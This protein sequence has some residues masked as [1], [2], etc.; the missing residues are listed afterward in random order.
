MLMTCEA[1][2]RVH[3]PE[4][5]IALEYISMAYIIAVLMIT[6]NRPKVTKISGLNT[7]FISGLSVKLTIVITKIMESKSEISDVAT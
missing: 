1:S 4:M 2:I 5:V 3:A 7:S 6:V